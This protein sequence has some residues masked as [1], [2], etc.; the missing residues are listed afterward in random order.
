MH[1]RS[2]I[3]GAALAAIVL[4]TAGGCDEVKEALDANNNQP[5]E[6]DARALPLDEGKDF[7][8]IVT[9]DGTAYYTDRSRFYSQPAAGDGA[10]TE[11][12][13]IGRDTD[14]VYSADDILVLDATSVYL[15]ADDGLYIAP[16]QGGAVR[17]IPGT[18][19]SGIA[20]TDDAVLF[21][22]KAEGVIYRADKE[23]LAVTELVTGLG[24]ISH[25]VGG[26]DTLFFVDSERATV[27]S[28]P[29]AGGTVTDLATGQ[30]R[31]SLLALNASHVFWYNGVNSDNASLEGQVMR[32]ERAGGTPQALFESAASPPARLL[33]DDQHLYV[34]RHAGGLWRAPVA[35]GEPV[36]FANGSI[37]N[38][39]LTADR[40]WWTEFNSNSFSDENK[41]K[42]SRVMRATKN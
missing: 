20:T 8:A 31:P 39:F 41:S 32:V 16:R 15:G 14:S 21:T 6:A 11:L 5:G 29:V 30:A 9:G 33:A 19:V 23:T 13:T 34:H 28:V 40:V 38:F 24:K 37:G 42:P 7:T 18:D 1:H 22:R 3:L 36:K 10:R 4:A 27:S 35:G 25:L 12:A 17:H 2:S 26:G